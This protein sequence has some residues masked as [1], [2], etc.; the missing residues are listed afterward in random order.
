[1]RSACCSSKVMVRTSSYASFINDLMRF[2]GVLAFMIFDFFSFSIFSISSAEPQLF[3]SWSVKE[4]S[5]HRSCKCL[6]ERF[7]PDVKIAIK[8]IRI[9]MF[10]DWF[11][12]WIL[13]FQP[14]SGLLFNPSNRYFRSQLF[15]RLKWLNTAD[16]DIICCFTL[17]FVIFYFMVH[18]DFHV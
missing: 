16:K 9:I 5:Y 7:K 8:N 18:F 10:G 14:H 17:D 2:W 13:F 15:A 3:F 6:S 1:M 11:T 12:V 4:M